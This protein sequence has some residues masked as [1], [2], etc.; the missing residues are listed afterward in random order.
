MLGFGGQAFVRPI[1]FAEKDRAL[2]LSMNGRYQLFPKKVNSF[3]ICFQ[4]TGD[5]YVI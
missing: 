1:P 5:R 3:T 2:R 4:N